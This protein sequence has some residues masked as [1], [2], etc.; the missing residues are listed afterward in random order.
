MNC[1]RVNELVKFS[2]FFAVSLEY[3]AGASDDDGWERVGG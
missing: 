2:K 3:L 1:F